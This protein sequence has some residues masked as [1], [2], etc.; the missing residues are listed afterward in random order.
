MKKQRI[1]SRSS[2]EAE[3]RSMVMTYS[4]LKWL[5]GLLAFLGISRHAPMRLFCDSQATLHIA[6]N[7]VFHERTKHIEINYHFVCDA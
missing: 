3:Y 7:S 4:E 1:V 6:M 5:K 2:T